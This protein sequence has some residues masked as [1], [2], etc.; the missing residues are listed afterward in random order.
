M[1]AE[2]F[3]ETFYDAEG[4]ALRSVG[5]VHDITEGKKAEEALR[6][7]HDELERR[8]KERTAEL[9]RSNAL[10]REKDES[11]TLAQRA[12]H[13]GLWSRDLTTGKCFMSP[14]WYDL[15]GFPLIEGPVSHAEFLDRVH[16]DDCLRVKEMSL[17]RETGDFDREFRIIHP[18]KGE[19]W[20]LSRG[21]RGIST[22]DGHLH[23]MGVLIDVT[24]RKAA[25]IALRELNEQLD[26]R[27]AQRT[28]DLA[29]SQAKLRALVAELTKAEEH[30]RRRLA[31]N[32]TT[33]WR[34]H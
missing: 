21:R 29:E 7:A 18:V 19:R 34:N 33:T 15:M 12:W 17:H 28:Q 10:L 26:Q 6:A 14:E 2:N 27:G 9:T 3:G 16:P 22:A 13:T 24:N 11:L 20:I 31:S 32:C 5:S 30:A 1:G 25:E 23:M 8:V 4:R